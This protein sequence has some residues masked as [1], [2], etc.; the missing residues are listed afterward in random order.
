M[1]I[2]ELNAATQ[3][4]DRAVSLIKDA[5]L[6]LNGETEIALAFDAYVDSKYKYIDVFIYNNSND[7][8]YSVSILGEDGNKLCNDMFLPSKYMIKQTILMKL[9]LMC[10]NDTVSSLDN[11]NHY[12]SKT[13]I[14]LVL[15]NKK[16]DIDIDAEEILKF[17]R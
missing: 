16:Y 4:T 8:E 12:S 6:K 9:K 7:M 3:V 15:E 13:S 14:S 17:I 1:T 11:M 2:M 5:I 10:G